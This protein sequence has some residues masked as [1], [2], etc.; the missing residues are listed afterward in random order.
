L[1]TKST[2]PGIEVYGEK[3]VSV[4]N[5][6]KD[7]D[8]APVTT[9]V[10]YRVWNPFRSKLAA[11]IIGGIDNIY[12]GPGSKVLYLGA[13]SGT[14]VSHVADIVGPT[15]NVYAVEFS[16]RSGRDL[17]N[18]AQNRTNVIPIV[19]DAR[20]P[21]R[22]RMLIPMV[23]CIF[24]DVAQPDQARIVAL[25]AHMFLKI[26]G[27]V[28]ISI[29]ANCIDSTAAP[30]A[31]F[32]QEVQKLRAERI[33]PQEQLTLGT[34][35]LQHTTLFAPANRTFRTLRARSLHCHWTVSGSQVKLMPPSWRK[36][37]VLDLRLY[38][39]WMC[40]GIYPR[41]LI[42]WSF[43]PAKATGVGDFDSCLF[44]IVTNNDSVTA[45]I[46]CISRPFW[47]LTS[48]SL[49]DAHIAIAHLLESTY[50]LW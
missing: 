38:Y 50:E 44:R 3:R 18:M 8:G 9:K 36:G 45:D 23:D 10:E 14:S 34:C 49:I 37:E 27:G 29:K 39:S 21:M 32:A 20:H 13:A 22:Y 5:T 30:E 43:H 24:A 11:G 47:F 19:E 12:M 48:C 31:V 2:A 15:G 42:R 26:G 17:V 35:K 7:D 33:K 1:L 28:V 40:L 25:N 6:S 41:R 46:T 4:E 16:H